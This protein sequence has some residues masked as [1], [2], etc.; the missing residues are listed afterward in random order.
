ME[1]CAQKSS[2]KYKTSNRIYQRPP[3]YMTP[4]CLPFEKNAIFYKEQNPNRKERMNMCRINN[5]CV[6]D[7]NY[8]YLNERGVKPS[9][10]FSKTVSSLDLPVEKSR[11]HDG[12]L[13][14]PIR[15]YTQELDIKPIQVVY[16]SIHDNVSNNPELNGYG[17]NYKGYSTITGG[18]IQYYIDKQQAEPFYSPVY[19][20]KTEAVGKMYMD[21]MGT[22]RPQFDKAYK[23]D[24]FT[25]LSWLDD[26]TAQ[27]DDIIALQ[28]RKHN[29]QKFELMYN[30]L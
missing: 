22:V 15:N 14:D 27:R 6:D 10:Y 16:N 1:I 17:K 5:G 9:P 28:Q 30:R 4:L 18:Q 13:V 29:E 19:A 11:Q 21:P 7:G 24:S 2:T 23:N 8:V 3:L 26:S 20:T 25:C 12:R